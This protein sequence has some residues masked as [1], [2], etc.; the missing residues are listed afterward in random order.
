MLGSAFNASEFSMIVRPFNPGQGLTGIPVAHTIEDKQTVLDDSENMLK[1][2]D[3]I[4]TGVVCF[5]RI[6]Q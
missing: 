1:Y 4:S 6:Q 2:V 5:E 3:E